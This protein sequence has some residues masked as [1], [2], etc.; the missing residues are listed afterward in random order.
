MSYN[1][2]VTCNDESNTRV[3][4]HAENGAYMSGGSQGYRTMHLCG[5][6][7]P[8][9]TIGGVG[10]E[11]EFR[12][13]G[14]VRAIF[15]EM[16]NETAKRGIPLTVLHPFSF[17]YY[18]KFGFER[19]AD[20][21]VLEF[22]MSALAYVPRYSDLVR[23]T[24]EEHRAA[25]EAVYNTFAATRQLLPRRA[26]YPFPIGG[27]D[28]RSYVSYNE[29]GEAD[30]YIILSIEKYFWVNQMVSVNLNV[31]EM[32]FTT[33]EALMKLFGFMRMF[34]G[35]LES[36]KIHDCAMCPEVELRLRNYTH[37]K[38]TVIPDLM[39]RINDVEALFT[40][41]KYPCAAGTFTVKCTEPEGTPWMAHADKTTGIFRVDYKDGAGTV[42]RLTDDADYD[43]AADVPALTQ[44]V[45]GYNIGGYEVARYMENTTFK[46]P[47]DDF[48]RA[49]PTRPGGVFEHF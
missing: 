34:E 7:I 30:G 29:A 36:V 32:A 15:V 25:M 49:F 10:T 18:R 44:L 27:G 37:T 47:A 3:E 8:A 23:G 9:A 31:Y 38:I 24:T 26:G 14:K 19:V 12:R 17:A 35:E 28:R 41:I 21:R 20:H 39:A 45:F 43:L 2:T 22:P 6:E 46:N 13:G 40:L 11:P 16:A 1:L 42:T 4:L 48:F 33:P 5:A